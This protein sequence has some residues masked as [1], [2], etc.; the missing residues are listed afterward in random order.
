LNDKNGL[1]LLLLLLLLLG[2][3]HIYREDD[4]RRS[5]DEAMVEIQLSVALF[6]S[7][8]SLLL[9][10]YRKSTVKLLRLSLDRPTRN[11]KSKI[12]V[13]TAAAANAPVRSVGNLDLS[14]FA[15]MMMLHFLSEHFSQ[16]WSA[17]RQ[18]DF[19]AGVIGYWTVI[20]DDAKIVD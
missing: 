4:E 20:P 3:L 5:P 13:S 18:N 15:M 10:L 16:R 14:R 19:S 2:Q 11:R 17:S 6:M 7:P 1:L 12:L 9:H 8:F